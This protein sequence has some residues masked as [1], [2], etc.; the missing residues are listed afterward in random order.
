M[1]TDSREDGK[2][3]SDA[4]AAIWLN[5]LLALLYINLNGLSD[6]NKHLLEEYVDT[7]GSKITTVTETKNVISKVDSFKNGKCLH[8]NNSNSPKDQ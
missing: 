6:K 1:P 2:T 8:R 7:V 3:V 4:H 5:E